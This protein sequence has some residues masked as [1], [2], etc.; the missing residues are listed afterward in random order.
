MKYQAKVTVGAKSFLARTEAE[1]VS[2]AYHKIWTA[3]ASRFDVEKVMVSN[4]V[5]ISESEGISNI[6]NDFFKVFEK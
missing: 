2:E 4:L 1:S 6:L 3:S 5:S